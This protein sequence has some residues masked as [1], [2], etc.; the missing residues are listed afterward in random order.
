M[1][2]KMKGFSGFKSINDDKKVLK[3]Y[4]EK[5]PGGSDNLETKAFTGNFNRGLTDRTTGTNRL[6]SL[7]R[8]KQMRRVL[9]FTP[10]KEHMNPDGSI[11]AKH[12]KTY[13]DEVNKLDFKPPVLKNRSG[14]N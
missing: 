4:K 5:K 2:F 12:F 1:A 7:H 14:K 8:T 11:K 3:N 10:K 13:V 9:G 6:D